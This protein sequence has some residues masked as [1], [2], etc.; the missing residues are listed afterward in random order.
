MTAAQFNLEL[1]PI[2]NICY[3]VPF[4]Q[5]ATLLFGYRG[6]MIMAER[7]GRVRFLPP[8]IVREKDKYRMPTIQ[9]GEMYSQWSYE[10]YAGEDAGKA[11]AYVSRAVIKIFSSENVDYRWM[12]RKEVDEHRARS[13]SPNMGPWVTDYDAMALKTVIRAHTKY[14]PVGHDLQDALTH[15]EDAM[16]DIEAAPSTAKKSGAAALLGAIGAPT[17]PEPPIE[18][19]VETDEHGASKEVAQ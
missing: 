7:S 12:W 18:H 6:L 3:L 5:Q 13:K 10:P 16:M 4:K 9:E 11:V 1:D 2:A 15:D 19:A 14:L 17:L 8:I